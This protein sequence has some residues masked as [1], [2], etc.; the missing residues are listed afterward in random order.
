MDERR[1]FY[2]C[3]VGKSDNELSKR[4]LVS[5]VAA[6]ERLDGQ[7]YHLISQLP[8]KIEAAV[9]VINE[10]NQ[11]SNLKK[12]SQGWAILVGAAKD[13]Y[14]DWLINNRTK[15]DATGGVFGV[16][17]IESPVLYSYGFLA[18]YGVG[19]GGPL[20]AGLPDDEVSCGS[21]DFV[22]LVGKYGLEYGVSGYLT[23]YGSGATAAAL[24]SRVAEFDLLVRSEINCVLSQEDSYTEAAE[25]AWA[26]DELI[27]AINSRL[28]LA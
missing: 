28:S 4:S 25:V 24:S 18:T 8:G 13:I 5:H 9:D 16:G 19:F 11:F 26:L 15:F 27:S 3:N 21:A 22:N 14:S 23:Q 2:V 20:L 17:N 1:V 10:G 6:E 12:R 7:I